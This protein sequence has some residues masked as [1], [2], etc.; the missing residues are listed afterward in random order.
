MEFLGSMSFPEKE[1]FDIEMERYGRDRKRVRE[2]NRRAVAGVVVNGVEAERQL[3]RLALPEIGGGVG[4][5][6]W[7][8][9]MSVAVEGRK[10]AGKEEEEWWW[11]ICVFMSLGFV[12]K[13]LHNFEA[14]KDFENM[15]G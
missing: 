4:G 5:G 13:S 7:W 2:R 11:D 14:F 6:W 3:V 10:Q 1:G 12:C 15:K 9:S 8:M